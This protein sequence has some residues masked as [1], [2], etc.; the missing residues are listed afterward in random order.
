M[1][2]TKPEDL[3][4]AWLSAVGEDCFYCGRIIEADPVIEWRGFADFRFLL[5]PCC[6]VELTI[7]L[8]RDLHELECRNKRKITE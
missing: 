3:G 7:R 6:L 1:S 8:F 4:T 2:L 5:H